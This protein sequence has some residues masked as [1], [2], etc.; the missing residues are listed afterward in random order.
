MTDG[1]A[2]YSCANC[3]DPFNQNYIQVQYYNDSPTAYYCSVSLGVC[4][5]NLDLD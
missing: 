1:L 5:L 2:C 4:F 3:N